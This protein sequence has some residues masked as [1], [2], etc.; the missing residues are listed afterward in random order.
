MPRRSRAAG[1]RQDPRSRVLGSDAERLA[2]SGR[3][4]A[5]SLLHCR[6]VAAII[7]CERS[8]S[9]K[10]LSAMTWTVGRVRHVP[11]NA[12]RDLAT[13]QDAM[14]VDPLRLPRLAR[15]WDHSAAELVRGCP[16]SKSRVNMSAGGVSAFVC[17]F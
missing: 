9:V 10:A 1:L 12:R 7:S 5:Q 4:V 11:D 14:Y 13:V 3:V 16:R 17:V 2:R 6:S 15:R 8:G